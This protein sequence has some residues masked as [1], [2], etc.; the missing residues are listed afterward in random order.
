MTDARL[1]MSI[2]MAPC[3]VLLCPSPFRLLP[4]GGRH[5]FSAVAVYIYIYRLVLRPARHYSNTR[6]W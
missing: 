6:S 4:S 5:Y 3:T 1:L 2:T